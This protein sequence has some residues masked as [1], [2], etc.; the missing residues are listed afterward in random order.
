MAEKDW[1]SWNLTSSEL[2]RLDY[3]PVCEI[4]SKVKFQIE[5]LKNRMQSL[6]PL[7]SSSI[8]DQIMNL[9]KSIV[10]V[11]SQMEY[12]HKMLLFTVNQKVNTLDQ[13]EF[14]KR[15]E[16]KLDSHYR[17]QISSMK[18]EF[19][20]KLKALEES[21]NFKVLMMDHKYAHSAD[22]EEINKLQSQINVLERR[23]DALDHKFNGFTVFSNNEA[24]VEPRENI[25]EFPTMVD[26]SADDDRKFESFRDKLQHLENKVSQLEDANSVNELRLRNVEK[27]ALNAFYM[28][29]SAK[30]LIEGI[31]STDLPKINQQLSSL[32]TEK[33]NR[34]DVSYK[35]DAGILD[36]KADRVDI[37]RLDD[38]A[39]K[40][41]KLLVHNMDDNRSQ[42]EIWEKKNDSKLE[43]LS[44]WLLKR[45][46]KELGNNVISTSKEGADI[47]RVRC[48]VCDTSIH[49]NKNADTVFGGPAMIASFNS[50][51]GGGGGGGVGSPTAGAGAGMKTYTRSNSPPQSRQPE[52]Q[53]EFSRTRELYNQSPYVFS[54]SHRG[55]GNGSS[56][57]GQFSVEANN[58][59]LMHQDLK[60][61]HG[62]LTE[63]N[64]QK[65]PSSGFG[66]GP[67]P[68][69]SQGSGGPPVFEREYVQVTQTMNISNQER[70]GPNNLRDI[71][72]RILNSKQHSSSLSALNNGGGGSRPTSAPSIRKPQG[73]LKSM[74]KYGQN[75]HPLQVSA[76]TS[77]SK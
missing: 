56:G 55:G 49:Q 39:S 42:L 19:D 67:G 8:G 69:P 47:G 70:G 65:R 62:V 34:S 23:I 31:E 48:L 41:H 30:T 18:S 2:V 66:P 4:L 45:L 25:S 32:S 51:R 21:L 22:G 6:S 27:N 29:E 3:A 54:P 15:I 73:R 16:E 9:N 50:T 75:S 11:K 12:D 28:A 13:F 26:N 37:S 64:L 74:G 38:I 20:T 59:S 53:Q 1:P 68:G 40:L 5:Y 76:I 72:S 17:G 43:F 46:R 35:A 71:E 52:P 60:S 58:I 33:A 7:D 10:E 57:G 63:V 77:D 24:N 61:P 44:D 36:S 14:E